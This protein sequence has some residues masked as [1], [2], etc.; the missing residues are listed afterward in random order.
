[1]NEKWLICGG[2]RAYFL[3]GD[4]HEA[5]LGLEV[6]EEAQKAVVHA[7]EA[8]INPTVRGELETV[9][10][11]IDEIAHQYEEFV[12]K[13]QAM[14]V[15]IVERLEI[16]GEQLIHDLDELQVAAA[17]AGGADASILTGTAIELA[18]ELELQVELL[19]SRHQEKYA[20]RAHEFF[21][22]LEGA[23][24]AVNA[25]VGGN[26]SVQTIFDTV[27]AEAKGYFAS[28][29]EAAAI[30]AELEHLLDPAEGQLSLG[31]AKIN[32]EL[33]RVLHEI[34]EIEHEL[35]AAAESA[36]SLSFLVILVAGVIGTVFGIVMQ[37]LLVRMTVNPIAAITDVMTR[38]SQGE[39][40]AN[41]PARDRADEIGNMA[42][43]LQVFKESAVEIENIR[44][45]QEEAG[46]EV[47]VVVGAA[48]IG[49]F[50]ARVEI[51][52]KAGFMLSLSESLNQLVE[53]VDQG[54]NEVVSVSTALSGGDLSSRMTGNY[55]GT[56]L[57]LKDE[58]NAMGNKL[59]ELVGDIRQ[60]TDLLNGSAGELGQASDDLAHRT[61]QQAA[62]LEETA[63]AMEEM[64]ASVQNNS[65][66]A[67]ASNKSVADAEQKAQSSGE[68]VRTAVTAMN[69]IAGS[70]KEI[71][72]IVSVIDDI[73]FQTNLLALNAAVEAARAGDAGKGFAVVASEV[74]SLAQRSSEAAK[75]ISEL[76]SKS[77][78]NVAQGVQLVNETGAALTGIIDSVQGAA[79]I[80][81][82][83][84]SASIEQSTGLG[85]V[86]TAIS[87]M[88]EMTQQ[89]AAMV[90]ETTAAA[91]SL[92]GE[93]EKLV[94]LVSFFKVG[95]GASTPRAIAPTPPRAS[96]AP[97]STGTQ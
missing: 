37:W 55:Q 4:D 54:L 53:T 14:G 38:L 26:A 83:V 58:L 27:D 97:P 39:L 44:A 59:S 20:E 86:N 68:I 23:L 78:A 45:A 94:E 25:A 80:I 6:V 61:E 30:S 57:S 41:V 17:R 43:A 46:K 15:I 21:E 32:E 76:I 50:T 28:F 74:R 82:E 47:D 34:V 40:K 69:E 62:S 35:E 3:S 2:A 66:N 33:E 93:A 96:L 56:F 64:T 8:A 51:A 89:N 95:S 31:I 79:T 73:A 36:L 52:G 91:R 49:D 71:S 1:L 88:D 84:A 60:S 11:E 10:G 24:A 65:E 81:Q 12:E 16:G 72:E 18:L 77:G 29:E 42:E 67:A 70:S 63:A 85:E 87:Q 90:E 13:R 48:A 5:E 19:L 22:E 9:Q 92:S 75:E 7:V